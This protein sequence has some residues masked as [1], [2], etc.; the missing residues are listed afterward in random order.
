M[1]IFRCLPIAALSFCVNTA[2]VKAHQI[3]VADC[4]DI[5]YHAITK[6]RTYG[7]LEKIRSE[8]DSWMKS[9]KM[10]SI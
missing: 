3:D 5:F 1:G 8:R 9:N 4:Y 6:G 2:P 7:H 10:K